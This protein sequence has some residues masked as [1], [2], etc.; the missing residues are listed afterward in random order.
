[1]AI[2][3]ERPEPRRLNWTW[4]VA[5]AVLLLLGLGVWAYLGSRPE[6]AQVSRRTIVA[7][8]PLEGEIVVPPGERADVMAPYRAPVTKV[9]TSVGGNVKRGETLVELSMPSVQAA[10]EQARQNVQAAETALANAKASYGAEV[11]A[12]RER[13]KQARAAEKS[14]LQPPP[15]P[16]TPDAADPA[17]TIR[18][19]VAEAQRAAEARVAA[20]QEVAQAQARM[21]AALLP[22]QQQLQAAREA[23]QDAQSGR[24]LALVRAPISGTV[25]VLNAQAGQEVG[26]DRKTPLATIVDL[27]ELELHGKLS[28]EA[29]GEVK[30]GTP[31]T[32][33]VE[34]VPNETFE[35]TVESLTTR[36]AGPLKRQEYVAV[37]GLKNRG[38]HLK[39]GMEANAAARLGKAENV[40]AVPAGALRS[41][42]AGR[43]VV[44]ALRQGQW[45]PVVVEPGLSDGRYVEIRSGLKEGDI[46]QV[47]RDV[48]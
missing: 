42:D 5:A 1:M 32:V 19:P 9:Y 11:A 44:H 36:T 23:F 27:D 20:E 31:V 6:S 15:V 4:A 12:A 22:Y 40:P 34:K 25:L 16:A 41:D 13:L 14:A 38:G 7:T 26:K 24:K 2:A 28:P 48:L 21:D 37:V 39:P 46:V 30:P 43:P 47:K 33:T 35:G 8:V 29:A 10:Y 3:R 17:V 45:V 18:E